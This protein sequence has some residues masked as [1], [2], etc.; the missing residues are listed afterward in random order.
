MLLLVLLIII[1]LLLATIVAGQFVKALF[2]VANSAVKVLCGAAKWLFYVLRWLLSQSCRLLAALGRFAARK[3]PVVGGAC[4]YA[5]AHSGEKLK[6]WYVA[7][8]QRLRNV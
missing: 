3:E 2:S 5:L 6:T 7:I 1:S 4:W 8:E